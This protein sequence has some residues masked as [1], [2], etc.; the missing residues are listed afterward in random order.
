M[1]TL[2][3][4][5]CPGCGRGGL[6]VPDGRRGKVTCP[7]CGAEWFYPES[8]ELSEV[9]FRCSQSGARFVVQL[10]RRSPLHKFVIQGI[11][12]VPPRPREASREPVPA[13]RRETLES[14]NTSTQQLTGPK[15]GGWLAHLFGRAAEIGPPTSSPMPIP[16]SEVTS[17]TPTLIRHDANEYNWTS[18]LCPYCNAPSFIQCRGGHFACDGTAELRSGRRFHQCFCGH[19]GFIEG[20]IK[21]IDA[22][23]SILQVERDA[24]KPPAQQSTEV[25]KTPA[26]VNLS[27]MKSK[28]LSIEPASAAKK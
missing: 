17:P 24:A 14:S 15:S 5:T 16:D 2:A 20:I 11:T 23:H 25:T 22:N 4:L 1:D 9:E 7:S 3:I 19:A 26:A 6:R 13:P 12:N 18:F 28:S 21:T 27:P 10:S 8:I